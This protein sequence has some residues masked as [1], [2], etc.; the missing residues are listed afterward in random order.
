MACFQSG[1]HDILGM[2]D[3]ANALANQL[4]NDIYGLF[5]AEAARPLRLSPGLVL[6]PFAGLELGAE[7]LVRAG[8]DL[9]VGGFGQGN[10]LLRDT[11]TG[12]LYRGIKG[13]TAPQTSVGSG[14]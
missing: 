4:P 7:D 3:P 8:A 14:R 1:V 13:S 2:D 11:A 12:Q 10:L 5:Q 9:L 6:R